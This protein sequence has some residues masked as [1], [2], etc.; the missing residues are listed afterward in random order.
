MR[1]CTE[2][3][4]GKI[5]DV[6]YSDWTVEGSNF[7]CRLDNNP[8]MQHGGHSYEKG[9]DHDREPYTFAE[10]CEDYKEG[11]PIHYSVEGSKY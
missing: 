6:G 10:E 2:C 9:E 7:F 3:K 1:N 8:G 5:Q 4:F 11:T